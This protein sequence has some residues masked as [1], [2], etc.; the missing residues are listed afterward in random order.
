MHSDRMHSSYADAVPQYGK[1]VHSTSVVASAALI[2]L[3][4]LNYCFQPFL[5][6]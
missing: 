3:V 1:V 5:T 6:L 2:C 4:F